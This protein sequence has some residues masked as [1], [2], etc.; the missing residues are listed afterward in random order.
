MRTTAILPKR[1]SI[2]LLLL[3]LFTFS[4]ARG[5]ANV[6]SEEEYVAVDKLVK[7]LEP[8][9]FTETVATGAHLLFFGSN[10]CGHCRAYTPVWHKAQE[11]VEKL[12]LKINIAKVECTG[13]PENEDLCLDQKILS[14]PTVR[15]LHDGKVLEEP[16]DVRQ[17]DKLNAYIDQAILKTSTDESKLEALKNIIGQ[18]AELDEK[19]TNPDGQMVHLTEA[20]FKSLTNNVP[21]FVMFH[22]PWCGHC[23]RLKPV[24]EEL[25]PLMK[26]QINIGGINCDENGKLCR[27]HGIKG[28]PTVKLLD[29]PGTEVDYN[30]KRTLE[31]LKEYVLEHMGTQPFHVVKSGEIPKILKDNEVAFFLALGEKFT[32]H[33]DAIK[34]Y[35]SV[36][37]SLRSDA[38]F[39]MTIDPAANTLLKVSAHGP[40][41]VAMKD[42]GATAIKYVGDYH[43]NDDGRRYLRKFVSTHRHPRVLT[44]DSDTHKEIFEG[45]NLVV[46]G[47]MD[48]SD[49]RKPDL[50]KSLGEASTARGKAEAKDKDSKPV[51]FTWLDGVKWDTYV[52]GI[53]GV[54]RGK[55]P[56]LIVVDSKEDK[57]YTVQ[58]SGQPIGFEKASVLSAIEDILDGKVEP[59]YT[60]NVLI[61]LGRKAVTGV[62][63]AV[64]V[65]RDNFFLL[66][67]FGVVMALAYIFEAIP[68]MRKAR[69]TPKGE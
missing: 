53:Y 4:P 13:R 32:K 12:G 58:K 55:Y 31:A 3:A 30:G 61:R 42:H 5:S 15:L 49:S 26:G 7:H 56:Y 29:L 8:S 64:A 18:R 67:C 46:M 16:Q 10:F 41:L 37:S 65:A 21:W 27:E 54:S 45:D 44:L 23:K 66:S 36:A 62:G 6:P 28:Y 50:L 33:A 14:Y 19:K 20:T 52:D 51:L 57:F 60:S 22:A 69:R 25:A 35:K 38:K 9:K 1:A 63:H 24:F 34:A 11:R 17:I 47:I 59:K 40:H 43:N 39:Y 48:P 68:G 2:W